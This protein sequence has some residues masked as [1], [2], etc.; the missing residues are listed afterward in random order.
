[1]RRV[2]VT[3]LSA[4]DTASANGAQIDSNQLINVSFQAVF[5]DVSAVGTFKLQASND[6]YDAS[7]L[8]ADFTVTHWTDIPSATTAITAGGSAIISLQNAAFRWMRAV[9][10]S[11][12]GG[13]STVLVHMFGMSS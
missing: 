5:G 7:Y 6:I 13:S 4:P 12:S 9:Y 3:V 2:N 11:S 10:V 1:M 8:P